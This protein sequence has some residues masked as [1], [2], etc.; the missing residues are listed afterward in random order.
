MVFDVLQVNGEELLRSPYGERS[1]RLEAL[2]AEYELTVPWTLCPE[3]SDVAVARE[4]PTARTEVPGIEGL[5]IR[6]GEQRY[7]PG[8]RA[9][10]KLR[11]RDT[12]EA[13]VGAVT[14]TLRRPQTVLVGRFDRDGVLR[15]VGRST[16]LSPDA[17]RR[18]AVQLAPAQPGHPWQGVRFTTP[19]D[20]APSG[21]SSSS[22]PARSLRPRSTPPRRA[23]FALLRRPRIRRPSS[24]SAAQSSAGGA[25]EAVLI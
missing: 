23:A 19:G 3:T 6:G 13:V 22:P 18:L 15:P 16:P 17:A 8:A 11:R 10:V 20:P 1:A 24:P 5:I 4:W 9:L 21:T 12:T 25:S 7:L 14:G 2:L